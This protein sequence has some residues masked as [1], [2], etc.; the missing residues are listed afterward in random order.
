MENLAIQDENIKI[1]GL[2]EQEVKSFKLLLEK[3]M[4]SYSAKPQNISDKDWLKTQLQEELPSLTNE[5]AEKMSLEAFDSI[6]EFDKNLISINAAC[7]SGTNKEDWFANK[8]AE[9]STGVSVIEY[10][11]YLQGIDTAISNGNSQM[12]R[13]V[14]TNAGEISQCLNLDG[15]IAEQNHV[16]TFNMQAAL[17]NSP[18]RAEV[19]VPEA[20]E[21]YGLNSFDTVI[22]DASTGKIIHQYQFK[23]GADAKS[24][25]AL[26]KDGN[27]NNQRIVVPAEQ[28]AEVQKAFPG[29]SVEAYIGGTDAVPV[30]SKELTKQQV[31]DLQLDAQ[32]KNSIPSNDWNKYSN[33]ELAKNIGL[34]AG[35]VGVQG[36]AITTG[37]NLVAKVLSGEKIE[38]NEMV[39]IALTSGADAGVKAAT[40]GALKAGVEKGVIG[41]IPKGTPI[42]I[43]ADIACLGIEN[44]KILGKLASGELTVMQALDRMGRTS[45]AMIYGMS[46]GAKGMAIGAAALAWIPVVGPIVGGIVGGMVGYMA[47]SKVGS[48]IYTGVSKVY[49]TA[50]SVAKATWSGIKSVGR[51]IGSG[52]KSLG[53]KIFG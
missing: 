30:R 8:I 7:D 41:L 9:A 27:Y 15:F 37:F 4:Q 51:S 12:L 44:A 26:I 36:A 46:W 53:R 22:T 5:E 20:G 18:F 10:G 25:I 50:K 40:A 33:F 17:A 52:L 39:N 11:N 35:L 42:G 6:A 16:N 2:S 45:T 31:K 23:F 43:I 3:F 24:T 29:K 48:A 38:T 21:T 14:T 32:Q 49:S 1:E 47:G 28:V 13:A 34:Q 19:K